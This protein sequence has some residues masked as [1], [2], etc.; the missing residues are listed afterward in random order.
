MT[1]G[2]SDRRILLKRPQEPN[3]PARNLALWVMTWT[4]SGIIECAIKL[5]RQMVRNSLISGCRVDIIFW[6]NLLT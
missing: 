1:T 2:E 3:A 5:C 4:D 6:R